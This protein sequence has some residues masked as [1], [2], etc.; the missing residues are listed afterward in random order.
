MLARTGGRAATVEKITPR[1]LGDIFKAQDTELEQTV[2][3]ARALD[4]LAKSVQE[5]L[6]PQMAGQVFVGNVRDGMLVLIV[7]TPAL[8]SRLRLDAPRLLAALRDR[9][10]LLESIQAKVKPGFQ[11]V[12]EV[13]PDPARS[14]PDS[15]RAALL[16]LAE[17]CADDPDMAHS[18]TQLANVGISSPHSNPRSAG[19]KP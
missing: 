5:L 11:P 1:G 15:A 18:L 13:R 14:L 10:M 4:Q 9:G 8:A 16:A 3:R 19:E 6:P 2:R 7:R 12:A 17:E